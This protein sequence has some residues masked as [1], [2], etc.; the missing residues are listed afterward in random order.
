MKLNIRRNAVVLA[1]I[2]LTVSQ[3]F[4]APQTTRVKGGDGQTVT[5]T[6][7]GGSTKVTRGGVSDTSNESHKDAVRRVKREIADRER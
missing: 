3:A 5:I 6:T 4:A 2:A 1:A 7:S